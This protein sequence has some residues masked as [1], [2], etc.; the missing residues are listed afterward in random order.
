VVVEKS[1][2]DSIESLSLHSYQL[3]A[4]HQCSYLLFFFKFLP[5]LPS[6]TKRE[7]NNAIAE[8]CKLSIQ[9]RLMV[10]YVRR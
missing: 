8:Q 1:E 2:H 5:P 3:P 7:E 10:P 4:I 6:T 9:L